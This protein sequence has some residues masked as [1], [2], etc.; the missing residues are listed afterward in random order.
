V[1]EGR[2]EEKRCERCFDIV[3]VQI[4]NSIFRGSCVK[5]DCS[6]KIDT[7]ESGF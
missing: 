1:G 4:L 5:L 6:H 7:A 3:R 2:K